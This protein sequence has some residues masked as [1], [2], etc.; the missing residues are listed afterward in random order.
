MKTQLTQNRNF[1]LAQTL[2]IKMEN[3]IFDSQ[4]PYWGKNHSRTV[5]KDVTWL[6]STL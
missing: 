1:S 6:I 5:H 4:L 3:T 2:D